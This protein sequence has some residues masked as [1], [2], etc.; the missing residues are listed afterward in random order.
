MSCKNVLENLYGIIL[1]SSFVDFEIWV[2]N[3]KCANLKT[4]VGVCYA[5]I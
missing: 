2:A 4:S 1:Q 3:C 5:I